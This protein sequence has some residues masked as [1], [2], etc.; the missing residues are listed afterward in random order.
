MVAT[1]LTA[2]ANDIVRAALR[3]IGEVDANQSVGATEIQDGLESLNYMIK[4][5]QSQSLHLW[6]KTESV[7]FLDVGKTDYNLGPNGD[8]CANADDFTNTELSV[9]GVTNDRTLTVDSTTGK[10]GADDILSSDPSESTQGWTVVAGTF[11]IVATSSVVSNAAAAA[12]EIERT[13]TGLTVGRTYRVISGFTLGTSPSV[14]YSMK[15]GATVLGTETLTATGTSKFEFTATQ[16]SHTFE[17]LNGDTAGTNDTTTTSIVILDNTTGDFIGIEL[18]DGT[19]QWT[20]IVEVL[21]STQVF[22]AAGLTSAAAI[23]NSVF[24]FPELI[25]RPLRILQVRRKTVGNNDEIEAM[26]WSRQEYFAQPDK[27]SQGEINNW[28]YSPQLTDGRLYV[29]QTANNVDQVANFTYIRPIDINTDTADNPDFP[30]EWFRVLKYNLAVEIA[31]EYRIPQDRL[32]TIKI[33]AD[34]FLDDALG[35]DR[36]PDSLN[37]QPSLGRS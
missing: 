12:G 3:L 26:Q 5:W 29:W 21:S 2:T 32:A 1:V 25:P 7:L 33:L 30:A 18:D 27:A 36:E 4:G 10:T 15:D 24:C 28:Y 17:I 34:E 14:T 35:Y 37:I 6:T 9:A 16:T 22:N 13:I 23:N 11:A 31:P 8:E 20:K 19:R